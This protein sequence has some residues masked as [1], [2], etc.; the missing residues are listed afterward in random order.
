MP[1]VPGPGCRGV[2]ERGRRVYL[3]RVGVGTRS[4]SR[5][6]N[7]TD[8]IRSNNNTFIKQFSNF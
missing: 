7:V 6:V 1:L 8:F 4:T 5:R 2:P 3:I